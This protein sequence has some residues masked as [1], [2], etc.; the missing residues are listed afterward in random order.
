MPQPHP[1]ILLLPSR[2][3]LLD[4][5][6]CLMLHGPFIPPS[7]LCFLLHLQHQSVKFYSNRFELCIPMLFAHLLEAFLIFLLMEFSSHLSPLLSRTQSV[8]LLHPTW[9]FTSHALQLRE[10]LTFSCSPPGCLLTTAHLQ[11][12][13]IEHH[14]LPSPLPFLLSSNIN[15]DLIPLD[16]DPTLS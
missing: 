3:Q 5:P 2:N 7:S 15:L 13:F 1:Q 8:L 11:T 12:I 14:T 4:R 9:L 6:L 16:A 10:P